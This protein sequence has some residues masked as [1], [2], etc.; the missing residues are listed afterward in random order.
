MELREWIRKGFQEY[1]EDLLK[2]MVGAFAQRLMSLEVDERCG[3]EYGKRSSGRVNQRNGYRHRE[4]ETRVGTVDLSI[5][6]LRE[7]S[8]FPEWLLQP[9]RRAEKAL[10]SVVAESYVL[11]VSTRRME[12]LV[13]SLGMEGISKSRVSE[14]SQSLDET[15]A[16]FRQR[17]LSGE[18]PYLWLDA[19]VIKSRE[20]GRVVNVAVVVAIAVHGDGHREILG[21]EVVTSE[22]GA[23]WLG[24][25]RGLISRGLKGG[26]LVI[27]DAHPGLKDAI[28]SSLPGASWQRCR[29]HFLVNLLT[30]VPK[31][32]QPVVAS[33]VRSIFA[34]PDRESV[35]GQ[36]DQ[37]VVQLERR[38]PEAATLLAD[39]REELLA[40][41]AFPKAHWRQIWSNN[42]LKRL[43][44]EIRRRTDVVGIF[45]NRGAIV[46]LVGAV[47][48]EQNDEWSITRRYM[49]LDS[50]GELQAPDP[51]PPKSQQLEEKHP[52]PLHQGTG[53]D[54]HT[55]LDRT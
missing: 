40:F 15:V 10:C 28:A 35:R 8:Y 43:N 42:P 36:L 38:F 45:P 24:F 50:L 20:G 6:K 41:A 5:P 32:A 1:G 51:L 13:Q 21:L 31:S 33:L 47:L 22:D 4:W 25:L 9:R 16:E 29:T 46:R 19:L 26:R 14:M 7:G 34:Q 12:R 3:A 17:P 48:A 44:K 30:R 23:T 52:L 53:N 27:S 18:Y 39:S 55:P 37:V 2:E 49:S 11:G 54:L